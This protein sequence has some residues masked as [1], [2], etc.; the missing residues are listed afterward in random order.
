[1]LYRDMSASSPQRNL[2]QQKSS[3]S[4]KE[5]KP[6]LDGD[7]DFRET[8]MEEGVDLALLPHLLYRSHTESVGVDVGGRKGEK[9]KE[10]EEGEE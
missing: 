9:G 8:R 2:G 10:G 4:M 6:D 1:M 3:A 7:S 5:L